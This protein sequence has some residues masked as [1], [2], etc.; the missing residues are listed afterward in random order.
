MTFQSHPRCRSFAT[1]SAIISDLACSNQKHL[2]VLNSRL[3]WYISRGDV[4]VLKLEHD[5]ARKKYCINKK[6]FA[7]EIKCCTHFFHISS[8]LFFLGGKDTFRIEQQGIKP[9]RII[10]IFNVLFIFH[11][12]PLSRPDLHRQL[13]IFNEFRRATSQRMIKLMFHHS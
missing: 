10:I 4:V 2:K 9:L 5:T 6:R 11:L 8:E 12:F 3:S 1:W 7:S 13:M